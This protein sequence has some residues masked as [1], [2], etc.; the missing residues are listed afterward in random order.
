MIVRYSY[1]NNLEWNDA[2]KVTLISV[3]A[4]IVIDIVLTLVIE[5]FWETFWFKFLR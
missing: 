3:I 1:D 4:G 2:T 5:Y